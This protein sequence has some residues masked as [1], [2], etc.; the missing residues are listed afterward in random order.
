MNN[1]KLKL[2][3][4]RGW[5]GSGKSTRAKEIAEALGNNTIILSTDDYFIDPLNGE[6]IFVRD[7]IGKA[8]QWN[9]DRARQA[10]KQGKNVV[11][12]NT[13]IKK[14]EYADY[15]KAAAEKD[16]ETYQCVCSGTFE[17]VH[18]VPVEIVDRMKNDLEEDE[19]VQHWSEK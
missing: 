5:P 3:I 2:V 12:D 13:N 7:L 11:I 14:W 4:M 16:Y 15:L 18:G 17:N 1:P 6:Y 19:Y 10:I 8:H 9:R